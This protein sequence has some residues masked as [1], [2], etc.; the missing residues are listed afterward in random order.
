[1]A[2]SN[3]AESVR[4]RLAQ[5]SAGRGINLR[6]SPR[7]A[8]PEVDSDMAGLS[9][10]SFHSYVNELSTIA[11][12]PDAGSIGTASAGHVQ[13]QEQH[14]ASAT[15]SNMALREAARE[16]QRALSARQHVAPQD[17]H[18]A[19]SLT[20]AHLRRRH[21]R[22]SDGSAAQYDRL[23]RS[24]RGPSSAGAVQLG[25]SLSR[26]DDRGAASAMRRQRT[27]AQ[28]EAIAAY[29]NMPVPRPAQE[30]QHLAPAHAQFTHNGSHATYA[31]GRGNVTAN[32]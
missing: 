8:I 29:Y 24:G 10:Q 2:T 20:S 11:S 23:S 9:T 22:A 27:R 14:A 30:A 28:L 12:Q 7:P 13:E 4:S 21:D 18:Q 25:S 19:P 5:P 15:S 26:A 16:M 6:S 1:M 3:Y 32:F 17:L 31:F